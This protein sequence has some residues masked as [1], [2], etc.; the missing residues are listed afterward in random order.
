MINRRSHLNGDL[1][2]T[3]NNQQLTWVTNYGYLGVEVDKTLGW[4]SQVDTICKKVFPGIGALKM[5]LLP[6]ASPNPNE[7][8]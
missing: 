2:V 5:Y 3:V 4:Q 7:N 1:N 8:V 6:G